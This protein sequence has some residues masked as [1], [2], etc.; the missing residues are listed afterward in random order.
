M[1]IIASVRLQNKA[2]GAKDKTRQKTTPYVK[3]QVVYVYMS[4]KNKW[5]D[6]VNLGRLEGDEQTSGFLFI[7]L[8]LVWL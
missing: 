4:I 2:K 5:K 8:I 7:C 6:T 3:M 1:S